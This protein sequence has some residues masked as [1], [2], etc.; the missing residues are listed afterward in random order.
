MLPHPG[1][2]LEKEM[3][4]SPST[5]TKYMKAAQAA[6][7]PSAVTDT[8]VVS[9]PITPLWGTQSRVKFSTYT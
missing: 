2:P 6:P 3:P 5:I 4:S 1:F 7:I 9:M 8:N